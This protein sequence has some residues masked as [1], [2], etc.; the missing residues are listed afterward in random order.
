MATLSC[1]PE[2]HIYILS[3]LETECRNQRRVGSW[4]IFCILLEGVEL[5]K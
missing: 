1:Q 2:T 5:Q 4:V 3:L